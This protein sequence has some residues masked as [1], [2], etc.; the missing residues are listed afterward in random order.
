MDINELFDKKTLD[1]ILADAKDSGIDAKDVEK[2]LQ[3]IPNGG[4]AV[5]TRG[6]STEGELV[7]L[8]GEDQDLSSQEIADATGV[9][10]G[11]V[12]SI[13]LLAAPFILKYLFSGNSQSSNSGSLLSALLGGGQSVQQQNQGLGGLGS[14]MNL[15]GGMSQPQYSQ[16]NS[17][18]GSLLGGQQQPQYYSNNN[19]SALLNSL[20]A[21]QQPQQVQPLQSLGQQNQ[22]MD[23]SSLMNLMGGAAQPQQTQQSGGGLMNMLFNLLGDT[24]K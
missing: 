14:L 1:A 5:P 23:L 11:K 20:L 24:G 21:Q 7:S 4:K 10:R 15:M 13:L 18:L 9:E 16:N 12:N 8:L 6:A 3:T 19:T 2:V 17:L 22:G